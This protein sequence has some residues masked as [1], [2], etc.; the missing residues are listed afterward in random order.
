MGAG[1]YHGSMQEKI[2]KIISRVLE[3]VIEIPILLI[4]ATGTAYLNG[5]RW[6]FL[7][8]LLFLD[9]V[10]PG[11]Y[12]AYQLKTGK[13]KDWDISRREERLPLFRFMVAMHLVG[14][15]VGFVIGREPLAQILLA[16]WML[17]LLFMVFTHIWKISIHAG[18]NSTLAVFGIWA[19][20]GWGI[21]DGGWWWSFST[22]A[23]WLLLLPV[24]VSWARV[25]YKKH[26]IYQV[27]A[28][29]LLPAIVLPVC[30][31]V[32]GV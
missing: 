31:W 14:V 28:G 7:F 12:F 9:A 21:G 1:W 27:M 20:G 17:A 6:K 30:F 24:V 29:T 22:R 23:W 4:L 2:A 15:L 5:Y 19:L 8:L 32:L 16:F 3:P 13:V 25:V 10:M 26:D 18:V 11:L